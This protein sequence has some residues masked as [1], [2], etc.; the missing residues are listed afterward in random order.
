[1][2]EWTADFTNDPFDD[3]NLIVEILF[4]DEEVAVIKQ[5]SDGLMIKWYASDEDHLIPID[6]LNALLNEAKERLK[7]E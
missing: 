6:W 1:M 5:G 4:N 7:R 2:N 3:Y